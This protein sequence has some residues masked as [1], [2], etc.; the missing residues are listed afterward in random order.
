MVIWVCHG[1]IG[2]Y[3]VKIDTNLERVFAME[4]YTDQN[5]LKSP[6]NVNVTKWNGE[7]IFTTNTGIYTFNEATNVFEKHP[8]LN[9]ILDPSKNTRK[10]FQSNN[11]A[12]FVQD[13]EVGY[14]N[15]LQKS[16]IFPIFFAPALLIT[17]SPLS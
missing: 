7:I 17:N 6:Y 1:Y 12:W 4:H 13:E 16:P 5:G 3:K 10:L 9:N 14:F 8:Y 2:I 15:I 11:K